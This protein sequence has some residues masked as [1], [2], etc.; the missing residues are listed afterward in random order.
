MQIRREDFIKKIL[1]V[2]NPVLMYF[3]TSASYKK[4]LYDNRIDC[5][6]ILKIKSIQD[7]KNKALFS[8]MKELSTHFP[9]GVRKI[10]DLKD[11]ENFYQVKSIKIN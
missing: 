1:K 5:K 3:K 6:E 9:K 10:Y 8:N 2:S 7:E 4:I 11:I